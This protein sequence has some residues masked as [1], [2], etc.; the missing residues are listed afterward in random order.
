M[1]NHYYAQREKYID[2]IKE[3]EK[4]RIIKQIQQSQQEEQTE[5]SRETSPGSLAEKLALIFRDARQPAS[6]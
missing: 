1:F 5:S 3:A 4:E 6:R 2:Y